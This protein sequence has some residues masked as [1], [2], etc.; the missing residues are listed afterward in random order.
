MELTSEQKSA[1][2]ETGKNIIVSAG[3]GS[4]K[5]EVLSKRVLEHV[6]SGININEILVLT[7]TNASASEMKDRI[8][9]KLLDSNLKEQADM[10]DIS[11]ITTFDSYALSILKKYSY[12]L[13]L[14]KDIKII[15]S[16]IIDIKKEEILKEIFD[17]LYE[18]KNEKFLKLVGDFC[19]KDDNDLLDNILSLNKQLDNRYDKLQYL[20]TLVEKNYSLENIDSIISDYI[21]L[22]KERINNIKSGIDNIKNYTDSLFYNK[23]HASL[24]NLISSKTY[25]DIKY[26]CNNLDIPRL[27]NNSEEIVKNIKDK[28]KSI[29]DDLKKLTVYNDIEEIRNS[30]FNTKD[31]IDI[32]CK[33]IIDLTNRLND[34][35]RSVLSF[36]FSDVAKMAINIV[37]ENDVIKNGLR[38]SYK[39]ILI[40]EY[41]DTNDLQ[42]EFIK[43]I[44]NNNVYMVGD[45]KQSIYRFR[46]ANPKLFKDKYS[47]YSSGVKG[48][49]IDLVNNFRS[50]DNVIKSINTIFNLVMDE[51]IGGA[52]YFD[53]HQMV[54]GL[55]DY[56]NVNVE[57]YDTEILNY[58]IDEDTKYTKEEIEV[59]TIAK[60]IKDKINSNYQIM[61]KKSKKSRNVNYSD[62][63]IIMDKSKLFSLYKKIFEY[64]NIPLTIERDSTLRDSYDLSIIKN[65]YNLII[66]IY[67]KNYD[68]NFRYSYVSISRSFLFNINDNDILKTFDDNNF[69][70]SELFK[71]C[72]SISDNL[73]NLTNRQVYDLVIDKFDIYN[74]LILVGDIKQH[75]VI[76]DSI[77]EIIRSADGIGYSPLDF[78]DYLNNIFDKDLDIRVSLNKESSNSVKIMTIHAS[79]GLEYPVVYLPSLDNKFKFDFKDKINYSEKYYIFSPYKEDDVLKYNIIKT[80]YKDNI[81][82][83]EISERIRLFY[84]AITRAREKLIFVSS[85]NENELAYKVNGVID[86]DT[87]YSY[88]KF[89]DILNSVYPY[90]KRNII[91]INIDDLNITRDYQYVKINDIKLKSGNKIDVKDINIESTLLEKKR[92][93]KNVHKLNSKQEKDNI[94]LGLKMHYIFELV[95]FNNPNY[96]NLKEYEV[97]LL[98]KFV[99]TKIYAGANNIYKEL[100]FYYQEN[101][102]LEHGIID[103]LL[104]FDDH[105]III[106][107]KLKNVLDDAYI[108]QLNGYKKYVEEITKKETTTYLYSIMDGTLTEIKNR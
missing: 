47:L 38:D 15:D 35:K 31:Y 69:F 83:E 18:S 78:L 27:P 28:N 70:D 64:L 60:D 14:P 103:L 98:K 76:L 30:I 87:R 91:N 96:E 49:K 51:T 44:E 22:L 75:L 48:I 94:E 72:Q 20:D 33:I 73:D 108:N 62:F 93:S 32:I 52:S 3:A 11:Y 95:D 63:A 59:F 34:Y 39:E 80:L 88:R 5:T 16:A 81:I 29:V 57:N 74:K 99:D 21:N 36:E 40:D 4:G 10:V 71:I 55:K 84:V 17:E 106:D 25:D 8:R 86:N 58:S 77:N 6:K 24:N 13:D 89:V 101:G 19:F 68:I 56:N 54:F 102:V 23:Y 53:E 42:E 66:C 85:L 1:V 2:F 9:N 12:L 61:D 105:N 26:N 37:K 107:Y 45:I 50:R 65:I 46:N 97:E 67:N 7:F 41:Q 82:K 100:E 43:L 92:L 104:E 79:K 90:I